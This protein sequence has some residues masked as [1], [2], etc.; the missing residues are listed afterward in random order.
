M[1]YFIRLERK[2]KRTIFGAFLTRATQI[3]NKEQYKNPTKMI[4]SGVSVG[5]TIILPIIIAFILS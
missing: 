3:S 5:N 1:E 4:P 2:N